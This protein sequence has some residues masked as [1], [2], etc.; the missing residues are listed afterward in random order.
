[1]QRDRQAV[2]VD[3]PQLLEQQFRLAARVDEDQRR[4]VALMVS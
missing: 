2:V 4:T 3:P 1:M